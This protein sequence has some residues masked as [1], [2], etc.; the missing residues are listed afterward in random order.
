VLVPTTAWQR[1]VRAPDRIAR[2]GVE[3]RTAEPGQEAAIS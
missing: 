3:T 1:L 2:D